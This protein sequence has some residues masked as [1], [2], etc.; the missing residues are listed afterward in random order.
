MARRQVYYSRWELF[1]EIAGDWCLLLAAAF[2]IFA[3]LYMAK[4]VADTKDIDISF[5]DVALWIENNFALAV[6]ILLLFAY[7]TLRTYWRLRESRSVTYRFI[8]QETQTTFRTASSWDP[9]FDD[10][11]PTETSKF[12][13]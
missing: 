7:I 4:W 1:L 6:A 12:R 13:Y 8:P 3:S 11:R 9:D 10:Y 2:A 5:D